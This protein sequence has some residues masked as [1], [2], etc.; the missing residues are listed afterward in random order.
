M[1]NVLNI[2]LTVFGIAGFAGGAVG[3]FAKGRAEAV[4]TLSS[5]EN[6]LLKDDNARLEKALAATNAKNLQLEAENKRVWD[7][8]QGSAELVTLTGAVKDILEYIKD[9]GANK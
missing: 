3:Y 1:D 5:K 4:I 9:S 6:H 8:A 2:A 7:K